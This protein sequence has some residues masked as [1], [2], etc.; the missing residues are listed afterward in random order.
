MSG[1]S[2]TPGDLIVVCGKTMYAGKTERLEWYMRRYS[3]IGKKMCIIT[4]TKDMRFDNDDESLTRSHGGTT[5]KV[6]RV[7]KLGDLDDTFLNSYDVIGID[8]GQMFDDLLA[9]VM[10]WH[11]DLGKGMVVAGLTT[12]ANDTKW[13]QVS[14]ICFLPSKVEY[15]YSICQV[16]KKSD[17]VATR[18]ISEDAPL[19]KIGALDDYYVVCHQCDPKY[20][21]K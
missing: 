17:A 21:K 9:F 10:K 16:C 5:I 4:N 14:D 6:T 7:D 18:C 20:K 8:E 3:V 11:F 13:G 15:I 2:V 1:D 12:F 19:F